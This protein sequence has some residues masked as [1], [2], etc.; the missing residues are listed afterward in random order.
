MENLSDV[1]LR[2]AITR[3]RADIDDAKAKIALYTLN[4]V[5]VG[6]HP[7]VIEEI[8][9]AAEAGASAREK[10]EFL[11]QEVPRAQFLVES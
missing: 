5:G 10:L 3:C 4:P 7:G 11:V 1:L 6:E 2:A 9:G 8:L